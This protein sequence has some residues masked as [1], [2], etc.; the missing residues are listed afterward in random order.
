MMNQEDTHLNKD[1]LLRA[2]V[3]ETDLPASARDHLSTCPL[4]RTEKES[5]E[6]HL[7]RLGQMVERLAPSPTKTVKIPV[8]ESTQ[9]HRSRYWNWRVHLAAG[10]AVAALIIVVYGSIMVKTTRETRLASLTEEMW[11]DDRLMTE[12]GVLSEN[13]LPL[14]CLDISGESDP[15]FNEEFVEFVVPSIDGDVVSHNRKGVLC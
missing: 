2:V 4:C 14:F 3:D 5:F 1:Q 7:A 10:V 9:R 13:A 11:N 6:Q 12:I 8:R 15:G